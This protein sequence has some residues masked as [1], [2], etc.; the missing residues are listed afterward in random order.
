MDLWASL[1][2]LGEWGGGQGGGR[3]GGPPC[4]PGGGQAASGR[5]TLAASMTTPGAPSAVSQV[6]PPGAW[7]NSALCSQAAAAG[8]STDPP[9]NLVFLQ[10]LRT[11]KGMF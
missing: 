4:V 2:S 11:C 3:E 5:G 7:R 6:G 8:P 10:D 1:S 9:G